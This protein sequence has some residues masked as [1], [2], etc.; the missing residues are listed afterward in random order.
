M[1]DDDASHNAPPK[2]ASRSANSDP[3]TSAHALSTDEQCSRRECKQ[4]EQ[5]RIAREKRALEIS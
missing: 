1:A 2:L 4:R 5:E 3:S